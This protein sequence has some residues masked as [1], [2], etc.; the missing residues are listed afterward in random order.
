[1]YNTFDDERD[2]QEEKEIKNMCKK[3]LTKVEIKCIID[4]KVKEA[5]RK[6]N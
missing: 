5:R 1:V 4:L 2:E 6:R 3:Y